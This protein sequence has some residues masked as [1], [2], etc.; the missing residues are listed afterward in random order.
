MNLNKSEKDLI[1]YLSSRLQTRHDLVLLLNMAKRAMYGKDSNPIKLSSLLYYANPKFSKNRYTTFSIRKKSGKERMIHAPVTG[2]K[3]ILR[4][5]NI[6]LQ[7]IYEPHKAATGFVRKKSIVDNA[8]IH[9]DK[10]YVL[11]M[12]LKDFFHSFDRNRVKMGFMYGPLQLGRNNEQIAFILAS[13]CTHPMLID[14]N[15]KM[16]LPQGSPS[17]PTITNMLCVKLDRR[18]SGLAKRFGIAYSRYADDLTFSTNRNIFKDNTFINELNRIITNDQN[19]IIN[20]Q[21]TR[22][23]ESGYRQEVTGLIVNKKINVSKVY[24]KQIRMWIYYWERY[25]EDKA[26]ILFRKD[27]LRDKGHIK[28]ETASLVNVL[29]GKLDFLKM[30]KGKDDTTY[31]K[32]R[33]RFEKLSGREDKITKLLNIWENHGIEQAMIH[34]KLQNL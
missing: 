17:S 12:D 22:L 24:L 8:K 18:L 14:G 6:V 31:K 23:Q 32:L 4:A 26:E 5:L 7:L 9:V 29:D 2:L 20:P 21:K 1:I 25:G 3:S 34:H 27:Y 28:S 19:L 13:L 30:V 33:K 11:N 16:V 15:I 10:Q